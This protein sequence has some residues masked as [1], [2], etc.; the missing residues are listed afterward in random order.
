M[1]KAERRARRRRRFRPP[2]WLWIALLGACLLGALGWLATGCGGWDPTE[3]F[4]RNSPDVDRAI[5]LMDSGQFESAEEVLETYLGTGPCGDGGIGLPQAVRDKHNGSFDLGLTLFHL[6]EKFGQRFGD[7][8]LTEGGPEQDELDAARALEIDCALIIVQAIAHDTKVPIDLRA[9]AFYLAGN[10]EFL[11]RRYEDAVTH[12]DRALQLVPGLYPEAGGDSI[13]RDAA[14]NRAIALR[15]IQEEQDA[16][17][18]GGEDADADSDAQPDAEPDAGDDDGGDD[19]GDEDAGDDGGGE[20]GGQ[21]AGDGGDSGGGN[22]AGEDGGDLDAGG[23]AGQ[24][25]PQPDEADEEPEPQETSQMDRL[26]DELE[27]AP[28]YQEQDAKR[29]AARARRRPV[30]EDK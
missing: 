2:V 24:P 3:P 20:D 18:D 10:L 27:E 9:R 6:A 21:D 11:R 8:E 25:P 12:Y 26:L 29:R 14:W 22:D 17:Q 15:R 5:E 28:T 23:D 7:E 16:G 1:P 4:E 30:M 13:G 19:G